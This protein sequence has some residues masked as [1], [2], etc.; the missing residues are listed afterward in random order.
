MKKDIFTYRQE[1]MLLQS[2]RMK[3]KQTGK[4]ARLADSTVFR[5]SK[6][7]KVGKEALNKFGN[8]GLLL[9]SSRPSS[10]L[11]DSPK[12]VFADSSVFQRPNSAGASIYKSKI[13][14]TT[15]V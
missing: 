13:S 2:K 6:V 9:E 10:R 8:E 15:I 3:S 7:S 4:V 12:A 14:Y 11:S 1:K 5:S